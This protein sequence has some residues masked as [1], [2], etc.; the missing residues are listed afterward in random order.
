MRT[1]GI[2]LPFGGRF[3]AHKI[4]QNSRSRLNHDDLETFLVK[5]YRLPQIP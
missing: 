5:E 2:T 4:L 1:D 3:S